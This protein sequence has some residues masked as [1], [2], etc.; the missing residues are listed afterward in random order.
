MT[1]ACRD[2]LGI[3][4][5]IEE[6]PS[7]I[8]DLG[9]VSEEAVDRIMAAR[10]ASPGYERY[11]ARGDAFRAP[12]RSLAALGRLKGDRADAMI[13]LAFPVDFDQMSLGHCRSTSG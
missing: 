10:E 5:P 3:E 13:L 11:R 6:D 1:R 4:I 8:D 7:M 9:P 12:R 2:H